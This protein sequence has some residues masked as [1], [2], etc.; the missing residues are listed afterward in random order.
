MAMR[1]ELLDK[2]QEIRR[3]FFANIVEPLF[4]YFI[5]RMV[6]YFAESAQRHQ[7]LVSR[8]GLDFYD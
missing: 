7:E 1:A 8:A 3:G 6:L 4:A 5:L 2:C